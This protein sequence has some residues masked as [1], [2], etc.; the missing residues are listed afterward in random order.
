MADV[1][2][3]NLR[4][5]FSNRKLLDRVI[6][7][8]AL[9]TG[10]TYVDSL[11]LLHRSCDSVY[12]NRGASPTLRAALER[13]NTDVDHVE[14]SVKLLERRDQAVNAVFEREAGATLLTEH[15]DPH[16]RVL[17][18]Q[19][20]LPPKQAPNA[21]VDTRP[22]VDGARYQE[23]MNLPLHSA[24]QFAAARL[25][26]RYDG[27]EGPENWRRDDHEA[28]GGGVDLLRTLQRPAELRAA[29][30]QADRV[31]AMLDQAIST[32]SGKRAK[33]KTLEAELAKLGP[34]DGVSFD[35]AREQ[36]RQQAATAGTAE[37]LKML[38]NLDRIGEAE[39]RLLD[40]DE[41]QR[42]QLDQQLEHA[43]RTQTPGDFLKTIEAVMRGEPVP[44]PPAPKEPPGVH[45]GSHDLHT[46]VLARMRELDAPESDYPTILE[47]IMKGL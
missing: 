12:G 8:I 44:E 33:L 18:D 37:P 3:T 13:A 11:D 23:I 15:E 5:L 43:R 32:A 14:A 31:G 34:V 22:R 35:S 40:Q 20:Q 26:A 6:R 38:D 42:R 4:D 27:R 21:P 24:R 39:T 9:D 29:R 47:S 41:H 1:L 46:R 36:V 7:G 2:D 28:A 30:A 45:P 25:S 17:L 10:A 19:G 16:G